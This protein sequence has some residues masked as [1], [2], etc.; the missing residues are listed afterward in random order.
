[1]ND[2]RYKLSELFSK[3]IIYCYE[4]TGGEIPSDVGSFILEDPVFTGGV[5]G[6]S[7][8]SYQFGGEGINIGGAD[9]T[10][11]P[12]LSGIRDGIANTA[13]IVSRLSGPAYKNVAA[14]LCDAL[15]RPIRAF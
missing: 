12:E 3:R 10:V 14:R 1:M 2:I 4:N 8:Y 9:S 11:A 13:A 15:V 6:A 5:S 7:Q